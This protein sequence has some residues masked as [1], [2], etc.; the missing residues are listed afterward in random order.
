MMAVA[1]DAEAAGG[2]ADGDE[3]FITIMCLT[4]WWFDILGIFGNNNPN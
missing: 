3:N 2:H 4:G 1:G